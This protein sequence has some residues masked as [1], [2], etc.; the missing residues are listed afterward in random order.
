M[1]HISEPAFAALIGHFER[2]YTTKLIAWIAGRPELAARA[3]EA[4]PE[5]CRQTLRGAE[6][7]GIA[8][9]DDVARFA[10]LCLL[11][12]DAWLALPPAAAILLSERSGQ[13][14]VFQLECLHLGIC[15]G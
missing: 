8:S 13:L 2:D 15:D 4:T 5:W 11:N 6:S 10:R 9:E 1:L 3:G 7:F 12:G 14:R